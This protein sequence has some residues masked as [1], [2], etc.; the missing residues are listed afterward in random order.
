MLAVAPLLDDVQRAA[1]GAELAACSRLAADALIDAVDAYEDL[2][3]A[4]RDDGDPELLLGVAESQA[5]ALARCCR[6]LDRYQPLH[7]LL[8]LP[9]GPGAL[10]ARLTARE[11]T[12]GFLCVCAVLAGD[13]QQAAAAGALCAPPAYWQARLDAAP[14]ADWL[15]AT[16]P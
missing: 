12:C 15:K 1:A 7:D 11:L 4:L 8:D 13:D 3:Q 6:I 9:G 2:H 10:A 16:R 5:Q 14:L